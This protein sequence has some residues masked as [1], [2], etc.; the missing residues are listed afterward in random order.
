MAS[1]MRGRGRRAIRFWRWRIRRRGRG[2]WAGGS[3]PGGGGGM[4]VGGGGGKGS[5]IAAKSEYGRLPIAAGKTA[6]GEVF[7]IGLFD[8]T[9]VGLEEFA[10]ATARANH[11]KLPRPISG[12]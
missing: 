3:T 6:E 10:D 7:A 11:I 5:S 12:Y 4:G 2:R 8:D 1:A 9:R